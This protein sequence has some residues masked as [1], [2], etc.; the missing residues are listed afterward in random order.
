ML[1]AYRPITLTW[2]IPFAVLTGILDSLGSLLLG[3]WRLGPRYALTWAWNVVNL[4]S[5]IRERRNLSRVRQV[6]D[7]ELFRYQVR[8]SI[9]L[10]Q[11]GSEMSDRILTM[12]DDEGTVAR[13]ATE[14]WNSPL[15]WA[16]ILAMVVVVVGLRSLFLGGL[17]VVGYSLPLDEAT[18]SLAR[19]F[20]DWNPAGLG[21]RTAVHPATGPTGFIHLLLFGH[22]GLA[23]SLI[24]LAAFVAGVLGLGRLASRLGVGGPGAYLA[25]LVALFGLPASILAGDGRWAALIGV[26]L[27]PWA[28]AAVT[29]PRAHGR[30]AWLGQAGRAT[31]LTALM[32][33]FVP[34]LGVVP[35]L[36]AV[37]LKVIGRFS[38]RLGVAAVATVGGIVG[39][40]YL[41][42]TQ[43]LLGG[44][45]IR[46]DIG[47]IA[48]VA[49]AATTL[50]AMVARS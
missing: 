42:T 8:G 39:L 36:F 33:C 35:I 6:G 7:E 3:R 50:L 46:V 12:F 28:L 32:S 5:T 47:V 19:F 25:G 44:A 1:K 21:S 48:L 9:R 37:L 24:T 4:P 16:L 43:Y 15:T 22:G 17:P 10:R 40:P 31:A 26:G 45:P 18:D 49:L 29:G 20:G 34:L 41:V 23:R 27:L 11:V 38:V 14:V 30:R 13:R 2:M